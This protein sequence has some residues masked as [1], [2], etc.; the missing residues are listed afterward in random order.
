MKTKDWNAVLEEFASRFDGVSYQA[1]QEALWLT[2][3]T[4]L[5]GM[6]LLR[7][8]QET[9]CSVLLDVT[10]VDYLH[11]GRQE[12]VTQSATAS[13]YSRGVVPL[14][15]QEVDV[16]MPKRFVVVYH[17][18]SITHKRRLRVKVEVGKDAALPSVSSLWPSALWPER[19]VFDLFGISFDGHPDLR[20]I[21]TDYGFEGHPF[22]KDF[23]LEGRVEVHYDGAREACVKTPVSIQPRVSVPKV[24]RTYDNR[25]HANDTDVF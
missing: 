20:R 12:W 25:Y 21:L 15:E 10:A 13:G 19:E 9:S 16:N 4:L 17:V 7:D 14:A 3:Q 22:R 18:L 24:I 8:R 2:R 11:Y 1:D 5:L 6:K 23:P